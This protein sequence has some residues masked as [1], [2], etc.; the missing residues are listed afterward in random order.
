MDAVTAEREGMTE[1]VVIETPERV[2]L[3]L[4]LAGVGSRIMAGLLDLL[5]QA[6]VV[7][8]LTGVVG[9]AVPASRALFGARLPGWLLAA[10]ILAIFLM[11]FAYQVFFEMRWSGRTPGKRWVR[12]R[13]VRDDGTAITFSES[14]IRNAFRAV[15]F[16][17]MAYGAGLLSIFAHRANKRL[18]D[19]AA[20]TIV[21]KERARALPAPWRQPG[22]SPPLSPEVV[23]LARRSRWKV[24]VE[25][26]RAIR[27]FLSRRSVLEPPAR[28]RVA[29]AL[30]IPLLRKMGAHDW[31]PA[32]HAHEPVLEGLFRECANPHWR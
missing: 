11:V 16:L 23:A 15:D 4:E 20:G 29:S 12:L 13:T 24:T 5:L 27:S 6:A 25:E 19:M 26:L 22:P 21:I 8:G 32:T 18:G 30:A 2:A 14:V 1:V 9:L 28:R 17:P 7:L 3:A 31:L 10:Y